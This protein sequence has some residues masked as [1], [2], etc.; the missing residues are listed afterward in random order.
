MECHFQGALLFSF[1]SLALG[2][3]AIVKEHDVD[4]LKPDNNHVSG[5]GSISSPPPGKPSSETVAQANSLTAE[6]LSESKLVAAGL[7]AKRNREII[8]VCCS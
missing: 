5:C 7:L 8:I 3:A 2:K 6:R 4:W 1:V